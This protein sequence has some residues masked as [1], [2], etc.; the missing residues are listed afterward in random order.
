METNW[1]IIGLVLA[2]VLVLIVY[3]IKQNQKDQRKVTQHF[4]ATSTNY[5]I[6]EEE[7]NNDN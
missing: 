2:V 3:L 1:I 7:L 4:N 6:D 5:P